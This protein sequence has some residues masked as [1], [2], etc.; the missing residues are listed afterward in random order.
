MNKKITFL[1][2]LAILFLTV[3]CSKAKQEEKDRNAYLQENNI[4]VEPTASGLYYI[5][6]KAGTGRKAE[7]GDVVKVHYT[8][9][10]LNG[11]KFDSSYD[12]NEPFRFTLGKG[13][14]IKGWDE[15]V[16]Y[17]KEGGKA[18]LIIPSNLGYGD[19]DFYSIPAYSTLIFEIELLKIKK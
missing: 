16:A 6:N 19:K 9:K 18:T 7:N 4:T 11:E 1:S 15:G 12:R 13:Q 5:E 10:L 2:I 8:G 17:M 14:V 3:S